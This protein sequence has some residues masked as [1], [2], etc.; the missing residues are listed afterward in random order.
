MRFSDYI[1][2]DYGFRGAVTYFCISRTFLYMYS[3]NNV[4]LLDL[5]DNEMMSMLKDLC[6]N[7]WG[8]RRTI[9][10]AVENVRF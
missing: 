9:K 8:D 5:D 4:M 10:K 7:A 2:Q 6:I 1:I 3:Y